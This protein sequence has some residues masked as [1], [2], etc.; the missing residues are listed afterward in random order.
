MKN[1]I[2]LLL[3]C[4]TALGA[5]PPPV[6][7]TLR[8]FN[9]IGDMVAALP[10]VFG[11]NAMVLG[12]T[13]LDDG[14]QGI[15]T[16]NSGSVIS[17]NRGTVF[18]PTSYTGRWIRQYTGPLNILWFNPTADGVTDDT[19]VVNNALGVISS[20]GTIYF[21]SLRNNVAVKYAFNALIDG[22]NYA[23]FGD[24]AAQTTTKG[25]QITP[26][27]K[28]LPVIQVG[29]DSKNAYGFNCRDMVIDGG[30]GTAGV[31][32]VG[33][34]YASHFFNVSFLN[35]T[36][37]VLIQ[38]WTNFPSTLNVLDN[39]TFR[40]SSTVGT[41]CVVVKSPPPGYNP[42]LAWTTANKIVNSHING[43]A[44][45]QAI[46]LDG[47]SLSIPAT[48]VDGYASHM[49]FMTNSA[50]PLR[51][52]SDSALDAG[53]GINIITDSTS[54]L[55]TDYLAGTFGSSVKILL[56]DGSEQDYTTQNLITPSDANL[57]SVY[58]GTLRFGGTVTNVNDP[59]K[60]GF[61][62]TLSSSGV[63]L[64]VV[65]PS[66]SGQGLVINPDANGVKISPPTG[67]TTPYPQLS[68][69]PVD[70]GNF[71]AVNLYDSTN[72][73][74]SGYVVLGARSSITTPTLDIGASG[75]AT[76]PDLSISHPSYWWVLGHESSGKMGFNLPK[77]L[78]IFPRTSFDF[79][80]GNPTM[81]LNLESTARL[82]FTLTNGTE[83]A[84]I[85]M[86]EG[87]GPF[88]I[89]T[90]NNNPSYT[91]NLRTRD[92]DRLIISNAGDINIVG[93]DAY[94]GTLGK[95][96]TMPTGANA[97]AG[98]VTLTNGQATV[99]TT[100]LDA[101]SIVFAT[102]QAPSGTFGGIAVTNKVTSTSFEIRSSSATDASVVGWWIMDTQ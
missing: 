91:L 40:D 56:G 9:N 97:A 4:I 5:V 54:K 37:C 23:F 19:A 24:S 8:T 1:L 44:A 53:G 14:G 78:S 59:L 50:G 32:L 16:Y 39:C 28:T 84:Y 22:P 94:F 55:V 31:W 70:G 18:K 73:A 87:S 25:T 83:R 80:G 2:A 42:A 45:D 85:L 64:Q 20:G 76:V 89:S 48:Y 90:K 34:A 65:T 102:I 6:Q 93:G 35:G 72:T 95:T 43:N 88:T 21:P 69:V 57:R 47:A 62:S 96:I 52:S 79:W 99:Y 92:T 60:N 15:F 67:A 74:A 51:V 75:G 38:G 46:Y 36:N 66:G 13:S 81:A 3:F 41:S 82:S 63:G 11:T 100:A 68:L 12:Y 29:D 49:V 26:F 27:I 58:V 30:T 86:D 17:T 101:N 61:I 10:T 77:N 33:G 71:S 7:P 98:T